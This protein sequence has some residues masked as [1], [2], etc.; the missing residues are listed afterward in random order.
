MGLPPNKKNQ[1][2]SSTPDVQSM[3][4]EAREE[5]Y[6]RSRSFRDEDYSSSRRVFLY[7]YPLQW[8]GENADYEEYK[9]VTEICSYGGDGKKHMKKPIVSL[10][11]W[12]GKALVLRR[13]KHKLRVYIIA[14]LPVRFKP[15]MP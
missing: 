14:C 9:E 6:V 8:G 4:T 7:S 12:K 1:K 11:R 15:E 13:F 5:R 10:L 2:L 3:E